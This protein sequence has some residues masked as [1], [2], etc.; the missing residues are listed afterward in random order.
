MRVVLL[1]AFI[2]LHLESVKCQVEVPGGVDKVG[3][4]GKV[5]ASWYQDRVLWVRLPVGHVE[6][7][8]G[9]LRDA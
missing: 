1:A 6:P 7:L 3:V 5:G 2:R 9:V 8:A 4:A